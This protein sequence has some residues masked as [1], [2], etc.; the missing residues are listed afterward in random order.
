MR[1]KVYGECTGR[2][3]GQLSVRQRVRLDRYV[4]AKLK[5]LKC[6]MLIE[7]TDEEINHL[8]SLKSETAIDN[9]VHSI[10]ARHWDE[11]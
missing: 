6:E 4:D 3:P 8:Y 1:V 7:A 11:L 2:K 5:M 9:A 10:I